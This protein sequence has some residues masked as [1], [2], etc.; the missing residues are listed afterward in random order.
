MQFYNTQIEMMR[1]WPL[2]LFFVGIVCI[3]IRKHSK[4]YRLRFITKLHYYSLNSPLYLRILYK[5]FFSLL[6]LA[7]L[8]FLFASLQPRLSYVRKIKDDTT[9]HILLLLDISPSMSVRDIDNQSRWDAVKEEL[10]V[11]L[12]R[13]IQANIAVVAFS[14]Y[15]STIVPFTTDYRFIKEAIHSIRLGQ[16]GEGTAFS[17][18]VIFAQKLLSVIQ[19]EKRHLV[20]ISDGLQNSGINTMQSAE[21]VINNSSLMLSIAHVGTNEASDFVYTSPNDE[22]THI[23]NIEPVNTNI[24]LPFSEKIQ[25]EYQQTESKADMREFFSTIYYNVVSNSSY[26]TTTDYRDISRVLFFIAVFMVCG[27]AIIKL[28]FLRAI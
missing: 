5:L 17:D 4:Q 10:Q 13:D 24:L 16:M 23:G 20:I 2:A 22:L 12:E 15:V 21:K 3:Y 18:A 28:V 14:D 26:V 11:F 1:L 7:F 25:A 6:L 19:S 8:F 27:A 9:V